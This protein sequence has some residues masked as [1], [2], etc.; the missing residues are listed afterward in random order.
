MSLRFGDDVSR[1]DAEVR[2]ALLERTGSAEA[3]ARAAPGVPAE[4]HRRLD[5]DAHAA[6]AQHVGA[7]VDGLG[8]CLESLL[9]VQRELETGRLVAPLGLDGP[10]VQGYTLNLLESRAELPKIAKLPAR[11]FKE[12]EGRRTD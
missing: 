7:A 3:A 10:K 4:A 12:L 5:A 6:L 8:V 11:L 1:G 9:L 2:V